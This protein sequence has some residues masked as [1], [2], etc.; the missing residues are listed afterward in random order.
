MTLNKSSNVRLSPTMG[1]S[2]LKTNTVL[3]QYLHVG[4]SYFDNFV[5]EEAAASFENSAILYSVSSGSQHLWWLFMSGPPNP[6][7]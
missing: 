3:S 6:A 1:C 5:E 4:A 7:F 2:Y